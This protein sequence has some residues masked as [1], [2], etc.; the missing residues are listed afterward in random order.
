MTTELK[1]GN[2]LREKIESL[3]FANDLRGLLYQAGALHGH[4]C[5]FLAFGVVGGAAAIRELEVRNTGMEEVVA[6]VETNNCFTDGI[7]IVTGCTFGNNALIYRDLGKTAFSLVRR[8]G[9]G[10]R[11]V[12][13][14]DFEDSREK[15]YPEAYALWNELITEKKDATPEKHERMMKLFGEMSLAALEMPLDRMFRTRKR[16]FALPPASMMYP[17]VRCDKCGENIME[18]RARLVGG[19][20][21]CLECA[22]E[23]LYAMDSRG[24]GIVVP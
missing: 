21:Y 13:D 12:L 1:E 16:Q 4:L 5:N 22:G 7:Q 18:S 20:T 19:K 8:N 15:E 24:I 2:T 9:E 6:I 11:Y 17:S 10:V 14:P 3:I 23:N